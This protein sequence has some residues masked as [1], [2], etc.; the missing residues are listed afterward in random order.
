MP[1]Q[2]H[3]V[4]QGFQ[5]TYWAER[6]AQMQ[7]MMAVLDAAPQPNVLVAGGAGTSTFYVPKTGASGR[8]PSCCRLLIWLQGAAAC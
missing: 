3:A 4:L 8:Q 5:Q 1:P 7:E 2:R 6:R